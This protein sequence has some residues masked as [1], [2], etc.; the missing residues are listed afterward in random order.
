VQSARPDVLVSD[1]GMPDEDGYSLMRR[2]RL[3][4]VAGGSTPAFA[5]TAFARAEDRARALE[6]DFQA[7]VPKPVDT[8]RLLAV[9]AHVAGR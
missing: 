5:V 2:V 6:C 4:P 1:I 7:H 8:S 3:L 9:I